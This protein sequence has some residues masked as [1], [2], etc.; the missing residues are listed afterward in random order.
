MNSFLTNLST[1]ASLHLQMLIR[2][3]FFS[4]SLGNTGG[5]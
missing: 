2:A 4:S 5:S 3:S 1:P